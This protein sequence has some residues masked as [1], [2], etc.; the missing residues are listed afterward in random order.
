MY[1]PYNTVYVD[2]LASQ[3]FGKLVVIIVDVTLFWQKAVAAIHI[4]HS[5]MKLY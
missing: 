5:Y 1:I 2:L 4:I 3:I